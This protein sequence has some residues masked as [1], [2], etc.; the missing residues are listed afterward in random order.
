MSLLTSMSSGTTGMAAASAELSVVSDNI[1]NSNTVG[2]KS[3]RAAFED[4]L[5]QSVVGGLGQ[6]GLGSRLQAV[7]RLLSQGALSNTGVNSDLALQ[8]QGFFVVHGTA[9]DG[10]PGTFYTR[11]GQFTVDRDGYLVNLDGLRVQGYPA[12][13]TGALQP[14]VGDLLVGTASSQP[15]ATGTVTVRGNLASD[16]PLAAAWDPADPAGTSNFSTSVTVYDSLGKATAVQVYFSHITNGPP[17]GSTWDWHAMVDGAA[18]GGAA[19]TPA[20]IGRGTLAYDNQGRLVSSTPAAGFSFTP[21]GAVSPQPLNFDFGDPTGA[22]GTGLAG[23]TQFAGNSAATFV[24]Q[25]GWSSGLLSGIQFD[26]S[27]IIQGVFSNGQTRALGQVAVALSPAADQMERAGGNLYAET[28]A[29]G[30]SVVGAAGQG[31]RGFISAGTLEQSNVDIAEQFVRMIAAQRAFE[32]NSKSITTADQLL[33]E[34]IAM[35]R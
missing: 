16:A 6:I 34:L 18:V 28:R 25:D 21:V 15:Q 1:A 23:I 10:R 12:D 19:G 8:G 32:A 30:Q 27:G 11:A 35:K 26:K 20:E 9:S 24:G 2:F 14:L 22:A 29:S 17:A 3:G 7:Q 13:A 31:G 4:A 33:S 5:A